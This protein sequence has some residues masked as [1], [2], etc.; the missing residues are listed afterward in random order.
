[1]ERMN[2]ASENLSNV[3]IRSFNMKNYD[4]VTALWDVTELPYKPN[5]RDSRD[6]IEQEL[7][8]GNAVFLVAELDEK[9]L[10]SIFGTHDGRQGWINR[11]AVAPGFRMQGIA[12]MLVTDVEN[13]FYELGIDIVACLIEDWNTNSM[14]AFVRLGYSKHPDIAYLTKRKN[15]DV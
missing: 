13:K 1:M 11:L 4:A 2:T 6:K 10:G 5:G 14:E 8:Y 3:T 9:L 15:D 12:K 7:K